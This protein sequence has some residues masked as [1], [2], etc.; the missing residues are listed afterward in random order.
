MGGGAWP[1]LFG[2]VIFLVNS[3]NERKTCL[4][5]SAKNWFPLAIAFYRDVHLLGGGREGK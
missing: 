2:E 1:I 5:N 4:I 3:I